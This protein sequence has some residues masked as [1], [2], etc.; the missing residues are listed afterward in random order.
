MVSFSPANA[1]ESTY[2]QDG[3]WHFLLKQKL[4]TEKYGNTKSI[5]DY[6]YA[7]NASCVCYITLLDYVLATYPYP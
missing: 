2:Q 6:V 4:E 5:S 7:T 1:R 3:I